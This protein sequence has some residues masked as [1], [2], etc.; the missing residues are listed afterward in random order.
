MVVSRGLIAAGAALAVGAGIGTWAYTDHARARDLVE[1]P[2]A[3]SLWREH[4]FAL[5][6]IGLCGLA[7]LMLG[8]TGGGYAA[9][10][11][12]SAARTTTMAGAALVAAA[13]LGSMVGYGGN[14]LAN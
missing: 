14:L 11:A 8:G 5:D 4:E 3:D 13:G 12:P 10:V 2:G 1:H 6:G 7:A 9:F